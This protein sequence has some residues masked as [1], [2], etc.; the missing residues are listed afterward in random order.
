[1][2]TFNA[3]TGISSLPASVMAGFLWQ[4]SGAFTAFCVSSLLPI[5]STLLMFILRI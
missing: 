1:M 2:G 4:T 3:L 5:I